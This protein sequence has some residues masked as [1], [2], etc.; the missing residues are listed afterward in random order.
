MP[1]SSSVALETL[2]RKA[3]ALVLQVKILTGF[4]EHD[5]GNEFLAILNGWPW[6]KVTVSN[7][8]IFYVVYDNNIN[9]A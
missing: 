6:K 7:S 3:L 4:L 8:V 5:F 2:G 9:I 1:I